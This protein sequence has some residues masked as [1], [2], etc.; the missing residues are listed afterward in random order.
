MMCC[1]I[2]EVILCE[3]QRLNEGILIQEERLSQA[4]VALAHAKNFS[5]NYG[6]LAEVFCIE[7]FIACLFMEF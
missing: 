2:F 5:S 3:F 1:L 4:I 7:Y 6:T